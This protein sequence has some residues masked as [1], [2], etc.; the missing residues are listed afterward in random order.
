MTAGAICVAC[1]TPTGQWRTR[2]LL[3]PIPP[4]SASGRHARHLPA[5]VNRLMEI[6]CHRPEKLGPGTRRGEETY[7]VV[8]QIV[9]AARERGI[10]AH[11]NRRVLDLLRERREFCKKKEKFQFKFNSLA[12]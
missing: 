10:A 8:A 7:F 9:D 5:T 11:R 4:T 1:R 2:R 12:E 6:N 3:R